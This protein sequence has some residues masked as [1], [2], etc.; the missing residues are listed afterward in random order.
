MYFEQLL[1]LIPLS[2]AIDPVVLLSVDAV[3]TLLR[4]RPFQSLRDRL[5]RRMESDGTRGLMYSV[6]PRV[7]NIIQIAPSMRIT[8]WGLG[9]ESMEL[10]KAAP[11]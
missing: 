8:R 1:V 7:A 11:L 2:Q 10:V 4:A 3:S 5:S 9:N 6:Q